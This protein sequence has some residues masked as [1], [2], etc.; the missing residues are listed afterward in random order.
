MTALC[1]LLSPTFWIEFLFLKGKRLSQPGFRW[2]PRTLMLQ[3][4]TGADWGVMG[5]DVGYRRVYSSASVLPTSLSP[6]GLEVH[7]ALSWELA[8]PLCEPFILGRYAR[9]VDLQ[10]SGDDSSSSRMLVFQS[11]PDAEVRRLLKSGQ[12]IYASL[13]GH[14]LGLTDWLKEGRWFILWHP[15]SGLM[16]GVWYGVLVRVRETPSVDTQV[17]KANYVHP[18]MSADVQHY[19]LD[20]IGW[21]EA[22]R[23]E[24]MLRV[25]D[26]RKRNWCID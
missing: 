12:E 23:P 22:G 2:A 4:E 24:N 6:H 1:L 21:A 17:I 14:I 26:K 25:L 18:V 10:N 20:E 8:E 3:N 13:Q 9:Y 16:G 15:F 11:E 5:C 7:D 19:D